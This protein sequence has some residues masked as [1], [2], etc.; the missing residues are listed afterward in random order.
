MNGGTV[1]EAI[2][3]SMGVEAG[4]KRVS[5]QREIERVEVE[6]AIAKINVGKLQV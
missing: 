1:G 2:V 5:K 4:G 6:K 3:M